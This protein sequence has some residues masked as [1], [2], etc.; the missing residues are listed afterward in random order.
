M[1]DTFRGSGIK[2]PKK[3]WSAEADLFPS[4][5]S[6]ARQSRATEGDIE[7]KNKNNKYDI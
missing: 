4:L 1:A 3:A 7:T 6:V 2:S 5:P